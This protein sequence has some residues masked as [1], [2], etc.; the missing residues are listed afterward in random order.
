[1]L[2]VLRRMSLGSRL[3]LLISVVMLVALMGLSWGASLSSE[4]AQHDQMVNAMQEEVGQF[5]HTV[6]LFDESLQQ[7]AERFLSLFEAEQLEPPF[8]LDSERS[9]PVGGEMAPMLSDQRGGLNLMGIRRIDEF[10][11]STGMPVTIFAR[12]GDDFVR[13]AT[14]L[15][16]ENGERAMGTLLDRQSRA[17]Q[18]I[19]QGQS[20]SGIARLFGTPYIT[21]YEPLTNSAGEVVGI[22]FIGIDITADLQAFAERVAEIRVGESGFFTIVDAR[23]GEVVAG[24]PPGEGPIG[25]LRDDSGQAVLAPLLTQPEG[26]IE[27]APANGERGSLTTWFSLYP[28][29]NWVVA[30]TTVDRDIES[31][32]DATR[33]RFL[34]LALALALLVGGGIYWLMRRA[35]SR[36]LADV[37]R[38]AGQLAE[39]D[40]GQRIETRRRDEIGDLI[41]SING[42]GDGFRRIVGEVRESVD[43]IGNASSEIANGN[44]DLSRRTEGQA[45]S[46]EQTA[47]SIEELTAT[48]RQNN[49]RTDQSRQ[50]TQD[51]QA[52]AVEGQQQLQEATTTMQGLEKTAAQMSAIIDTI[53]GIAFQT[54][55]LA[56][57]ASVEAARA[58]VHGRGFTVV[59]EEVRRLSN[60][61]QEA[62][63]DIGSLIRHMVAEVSSGSHSIHESSA[64]IDDI[65]ARIEKLGEMMQEISAAS[66][67]QLAGIEQINTALNSLDQTTQHNAAL[68]EQSTAASGQ[69]NDQ[70]GQLAAAVRVFRLPE[71]GALPHPG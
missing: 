3:A 47:A 18:A 48:V 65:T 70:A 40:L 28:A 33:D 14:S 6:G 50:M 45:A 32:T 63:G 36:P 25:E 43:S 30:A 57:N 26:L 21:R 55:L 24:T 53:D 29:W 27:Y 16:N 56:L 10:T 1:M 4:R 66:E 59:A 62:S 15:K 49:E 38:L 71:A 69:L 68:V 17:W 67:E 34:L 8:E 37:Q 19:S 44:L 23:S 22:S 9:R 35:L 20:Y 54:N 64:R 7:Q 58:G 31:V 46:L 51:V 41:N 2:D 42:I 39:G 61:C 12:R 11:R 13:V 60:R 5:K 52:G